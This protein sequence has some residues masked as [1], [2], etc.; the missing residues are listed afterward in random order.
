[1][2]KFAPRGK[3]HHKDMVNQNKL[4]FI[5]KKKHSAKNVFPSDIERTVQ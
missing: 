4:F 5:L 2:H 3:I 1:M